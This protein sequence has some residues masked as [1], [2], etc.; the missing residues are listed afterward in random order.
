MNKLTQIVEFPLT[1]FGLRAFAIDITET[2]AISSKR[3][4]Q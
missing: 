2:H 3:L 1:F 4:E